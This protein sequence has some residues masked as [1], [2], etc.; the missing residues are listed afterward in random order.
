MTT[1]SNRPEN[2]VRCWCNSCRSD[3]LHSVEA[4]HG[5]KVPGMLIH[6]KEMNCSA[7]YMVVKCRGCEEIHFLKVTIGSEDLIWA[8]DYEH[9]FDCPTFQENYPPRN[10]ARNPPEWIDKLESELRGLMKQTY[11]ALHVGADRLVVMGTRAALERTIAGKCEDQGSFK[12]NVLKF[13]EEGYLAQANSGAVMAALDVGSAAIH[14]GYRPDLEA[15]VDVFEIIE[16]VIHTVYI[17][18]ESGIRRSETTPKRASR[19]RP[20]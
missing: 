5:N 20:D 4:E 19:P 15:I 12:E 6:G 7:H 13:V 11:M 8:M 9:P 14:R 1:H 16:S 18:P 2:T 17:V 3:T 10:F